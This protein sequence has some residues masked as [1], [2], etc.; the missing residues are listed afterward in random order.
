MSDAD[1][2]SGKRQVALAIDYKTTFG[3]EHG[4]RVLRHLMKRFGIMHTTFS[5]DP[6]VTSFN[7]GQRA[8]IIEIIKKLKIDVRKLETEIFKE[9]TGESDVIF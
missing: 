8:V 2:S 5:D 9:P 7:E 4:S 1:K 3:S 6:Y